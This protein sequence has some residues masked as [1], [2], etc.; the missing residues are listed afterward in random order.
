MAC[1]ASAFRSFAQQ[2]NNQ[3]NE[4]T[5]YTT[6]IEKDIGPKNPDPALDHYDRRRRTHGRVKDK[7]EE[8]N[9]KDGMGV[10]DQRFFNFSLFSYFCHARHD[11]AWN[12][13]RA[14][15]K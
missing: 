9:R 15:K 14:F 6:L 7:G 10:H 13:K 5:T 2:T 1:L 11:T 12:G 3:A 8:M 4:R